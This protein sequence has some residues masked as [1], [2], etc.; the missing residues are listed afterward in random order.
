M[1]QMHLAHIT[2][3]QYHSATQAALGAEEPEPFLRDGGNTAQDCLT[4]F[5]CMSPTA[6]RTFP[7]AHRHLIISSPQLGSP[8]PI[9]TSMLLSSFSP[10]GMPHQP[11]RPEIWVSFLGFPRGSDSKESAWNAGDLDLTPESGRSLGEGHG[12]PLQ[13]SCLENPTDRGDWRATVHGGHRV[14]DN[15]WVLLSY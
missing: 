2:S 12:N 4:C 9:L 1:L 5:R 6:I 10:Q 15:E 7:L 13:Y 14:R 3:C 8:P 11:P